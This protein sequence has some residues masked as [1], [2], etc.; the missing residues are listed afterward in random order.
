LQSRLTAGGQVLL[1][2]VCQP[3][4][5]TSPPGHLPGAVNVPLA[6]WLIERPT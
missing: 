2:D 4:E 6:N 1:L 3:D 5:F